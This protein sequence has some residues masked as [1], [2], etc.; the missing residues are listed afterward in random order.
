MSSDGVN[1][2]AYRKADEYL[3]IFRTAVRKVLAENR[4]RGI[5]NVYSFNGVHYFELPNGEYSR[6]PANLSGADKGNV[7]SG[8]T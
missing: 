3:R 1:I 6:A 4:R 5:V 7:T 2:E 8:D